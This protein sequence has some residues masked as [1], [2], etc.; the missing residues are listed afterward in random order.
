MFVFTCDVY[1][2][3]YVPDMRAFARKERNLH[4][5]V[6]V[7][8]ENK[9]TLLP[10]GSLDSFWIMR[11]QRP[12]RRDKGLLAS[13]LQTLLLLALSSAAKIMSRYLKVG[14]I[15][16]SSLIDHDASTDCWCCCC[17]PTLRSSRSCS[18]AQRSIK[19]AS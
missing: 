15:S 4:C 16:M 10:F 1:N 8:A 6:H 14:T 18:F 3:N 2:A 12:R 11:S 17:S 5:D 9:H 13:V 7:T 19:F